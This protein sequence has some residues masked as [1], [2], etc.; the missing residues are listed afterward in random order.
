MEPSRP[1]DPPACRLQQEADFDYSNG[2]EPGWLVVAEHGEVRRAAKDAGLDDNAVH[3]ADLDGEAQVE[4][5]SALCPEG[6]TFLTLLALL[7][8]R[9]VPFRLYRQTGRSGSSDHYRLRVFPEPGSETKAV[10]HRFHPAAE[11][12]VSD[13]QE[14]MHQAF[15]YFLKSS[16]EPKDDGGG[17]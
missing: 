5:P 13:M 7:N 14:Y 15:A 9:N 8:Q 6:T 4:H 2:G 16:T 12:A 1:T 3:P 17:R 10:L 11:A